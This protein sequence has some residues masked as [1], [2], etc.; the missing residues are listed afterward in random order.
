MLTSVTSRKAIMIPFAVSES[1]KPDFISS[2]DKNCMIPQCLSIDDKTEKAIIV[3]QITAIER[4]AVTMLF[5][6]V[7]VVSVNENSF[8]GG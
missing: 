5:V 2:P 8:F 4:P 7:S 1:K 3:K 6:R